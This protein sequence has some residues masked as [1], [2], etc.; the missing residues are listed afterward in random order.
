MERMHNLFSQKSLIAVLL[1]L[2]FP[3]L[4]HHFL[5]IQ[6][7]CQLRLEPIVISEVTECQFFLNDPL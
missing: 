6:P 7:I 4:K 5:I 3:N 1:S 2:I